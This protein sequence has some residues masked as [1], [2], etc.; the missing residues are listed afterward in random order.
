MGEGRI[1]LNIGVP[2]AGRG[3]HLKRKVTFERVVEWIKEQGHD[4]YITKALI[5]K[6][7]GFPDRTYHVFRKNFNI[8]LAQIQKERKD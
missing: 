2:N 4:E 6:A 3:G 8:Y 5:K 1:D 7:S